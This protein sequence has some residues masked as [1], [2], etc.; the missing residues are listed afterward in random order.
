MPTRYTVVIIFVALFLAL[1]NFVNTYVKKDFDSALIHMFIIGSCVT[2]LCGYAG[3]YLEDASRA[4][5]EQ[6][7]EIARRIS[8]NN[9][10]QNG[11]GQ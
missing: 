10:T 11:P 8:G 3:R 1:Y 6:N 5:K 7:D 4:A 9:S 2:S